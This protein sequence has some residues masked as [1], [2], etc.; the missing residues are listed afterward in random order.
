MVTPSFQEYAMS[1]WTQGKNDVR[2]G[3]KIGSIELEACMRR[4]FVMPSYKK[5]NKL[6]EEEKE[7]VRKGRKFVDEEQEF[8][9][10]NEFREKLQ[11][12]IINK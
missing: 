12:L 8:I 10:E 11:T 5:N 4:K 2:I 3:K 9:R 7:L 6:Q 1:W